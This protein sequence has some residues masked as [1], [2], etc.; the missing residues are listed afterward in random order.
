MMDFSPIGPQTGGIG[1]QAP[2]N[3][4]MAKARQVYWQY[5]ANK[6]L[7]FKTDALLI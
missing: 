5:C 7:D 1:G 3:D 4:A 2:M 6:Y